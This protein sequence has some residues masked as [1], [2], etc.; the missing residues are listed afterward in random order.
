MHG[1]FVLLQVLRLILSQEEEILDDRCSK[2]VV[3]P[4]LY[5]EASVN[6]QRLQVVQLLLIRAIVLDREAEEVQATRDTLTDYVV[7]ISDPID[8]EDSH[9]AKHSKGGAC[10][11]EEY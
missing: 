4:L 7:N 10:L 9:C 6:D 2:L 5:L 3:L 11:V 8:V 1:E